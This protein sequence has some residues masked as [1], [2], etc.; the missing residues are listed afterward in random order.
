M[1]SNGGANG[2]AGP[3]LETSNG[4]G[5]TANNPI[6]AALLQAMSS[7][8]ATVQPSQWIQPQAA[9]QLQQQAL[10][11]AAPVLDA[12]ASNANQLQTFLTAL[13][14]KQPLKQEHAD[15]GQSVPAASHHQQAQTFASVGP[16]VSQSVQ[17]SAQTASQGQSHFSIPT[18]SQQQQPH[19][20]QQHHQYQQ[21]SQS[22]AL[23]TQPQ[24]GYP[25]QHLYQVPSQIP[26]QQVQ[27]LTAQV[28]QGHQA[29]LPATPQNQ[30]LSSPTLQFIPPKTQ[31]QDQAPPNQ[32]QQQEALFHQLMQQLQAQ[33]ASAQTQ[34][35]AL[36]EKRSP[37]PSTQESRNQATLQIQAPSQALNPGQPHRPGSY[38]A[39]V[40]QQPNQAYAINVQQQQNMVSV[41]QPPQWPLQQQQQATAAQNQDQLQASLQQAL[42]TLQ[43][44]ATGLPTQTEPQLPQQQAQFQN[45]VSVHQHG[46]QA[47]TTV[48]TQGQPSPSFA[49]QIPQQ[50]QPNSLL[51]QT[52]LHRQP[53]IGPPKQA[54]QPLA[55]HNHG[56]SSANSQAS[57]QPAGQTQPHGHSPN[58]AQAQQLL[59]LLESLLS[60]PGQNPMQQDIQN[61]LQQLVGGGQQQQHQQPQLS[62]QEQQQEQ[63]ERTIADAFGLRFTPQP[64][65]Q[66][67]PNPPANSSDGNDVAALLGG[68][69]AN[70]GNAQQQLQP[71]LQLIQQQPQ[72]PL[73]QQP[74]QVIQEHPQS[75]QQQPQHLIQQQPQL[76]LQ[77]QPQQFTHQTYPQTFQM[78]APAQAA[79]FSSHQ[80][81]VVYQQQ[82]QQGAPFQQQGQVQALQTSSQNANQQ[83]MSTGKQLQNALM[84]ERSQQHRMDEITKLLRNEKAK[85]QLK[86]QMQIEEAEIAEQQKKLA[87]RAYAKEKKRRLK[88]IRR[89]GEKSQKL[90]DN[91]PRGLMLLARQVETNSQSSS[92]GTGTSAM[93]SSE[94]NSNGK[95][96]SSDSGKEGS[97]EEQTSSDSG[98]EGSPEQQTSS[99]SGKEDLAEA[100]PLPPTL[101]AT[102]G[103]FA[104]GGAAMQRHGLAAVPRVGSGLQVPQQQVSSSILPNGQQ[105]GHVPCYVTV[106]QQSHNPP[107]RGNRQQIAP[108]PIA[109]A[110]TESLTSRKRE[111]GRPSVF[112]QTVHLM[113]S[114][115]ERLGMH[116]IASW[117]PGSNSHFAIHKN[118]EFVNCVMPTYFNT[119]NLASFQRQ[120][121]MY[122]F[123][124]VTDD[125][126]EKGAYH[127]ELFIKNQPLLSTKIKRKQVAGKKAAAATSST[128]TA[129]RPVN[130]KSGSPDTTSSD[131]NS[132]LA[133]RKKHRKKAP[134]SSDSNSDHAPNQDHSEKTRATS[135]SNRDHAPSQKQSKKAATPSD[136][137]KKSQVSSGSKSDHGPSQKHRQKVAKPFDPKNQLALSQNAPVATSIT[138]SNSSS[139]A[140]KPGV[141]SSDSN[142]NSSRAGKVGGGSCDSNSSQAA[143]EGG[144]SDC[145]SKSTS[146][147]KD[148]GNK[149]DKTLS[150][151]QSFKNQTRVG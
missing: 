53:S 27:A 106:P 110:A 129:P 38:S 60:M 34:T 54:S 46:T 20:I 107:T 112:P 109:S 9:P 114:D 99:D 31:Q 25:S 101:P 115:L 134:V 111:R 47:P 86:F 123:V 87:K 39:M 139:K 59:Q 15:H 88:Q 4:T 61:V 3:H 7:S 71:Q 105:S 64:Q 48:N 79:P 69:L 18:H 104:A 116:D 142:S 68:L 150:S 51:Q 78:V 70:L 94:S 90:D 127:H 24:Q 75:L 96:T 144:S 33:Q 50:R 124:R 100:T 41:Q 28:Q 56:A 136:P 126:Q 118:K 62:Q 95:Q 149:G 113:L 119:N 26:A 2:A 45:S 92:T 55:P 143:K 40:Q 135:A 65:P 85:S 52:P 42:A 82:P 6:M 12:S 76:Q 89:G 130:V 5:N 140:A 14:Q 37:I 11:F 49:A 102:S 141:S 29:T 132:E 35:T 93:T 66:Q 72:Q 30:P 32:L 133:P 73:Q 151:K 98:K 16:N 19:M 81:P 137:R 121:N 17:G 10:P 97:T 145:S 117:I 120:M 63:L 21:Q 36:N 131:S 108:R 8:N 43:A 67:A 57:S 103:P 138:S 122:G 74:L 77:H 91:V 80:A 23:S 146:N 22:Q 84:N 147:E 83:P 1:S 44:Q 128:S 13:T 125:C 58:S 148:P